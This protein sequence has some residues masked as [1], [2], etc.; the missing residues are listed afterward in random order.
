MLPT[1]K[2]GAMTT[3]LFPTSSFADALVSMA[4]EYKIGR[5][6]IDEID[7]KTFIG[8]ITM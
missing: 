4:L 5:R 8:L 2:N 1:Y 3:E 7:L 6:T